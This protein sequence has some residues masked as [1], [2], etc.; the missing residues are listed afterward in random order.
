VTPPWR[1]SSRS[2]GGGN[3][4]EVAQQPQPFPAWPAGGPVAV[5]DSKRPDGAWLTFT[6]AAWAAFLR[7][8]K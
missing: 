7:G 5:R 6:P 2:Y 3:C 8:L 1:T 4:V